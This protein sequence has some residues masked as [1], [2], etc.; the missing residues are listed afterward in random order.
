MKRRDFIQYGGA[1]TA[2]ALMPLSCWSGPDQETYPM[3]LQLY[4]VRD[5][6]ERD[7]IGTLLRL[8]A[9]GYTHFESYGFDT[10]TGQ[11]YGMTPKEFKGQLDALGLSTTS[12]HYGFADQFD[13]SH[14]HLMDYT[15]RCI[16]GALAIDDQYIVWPILREAHHSLLGYQQLAEKLN[17]IG[18]RCKAA[19]VG[20]AYHNFGYDFAQYDGVMGYDVVLHDTQADLVQMEVDFYWVMHAGVISPRALI[21]KAPGRFP[22]WHIKDMDK[23]TR[24]YTEMGNGSIDYKNLLPDPKRSGLMHYYVEQGGNFLINSMESVKQSARYVDQELGH[25]FR[26]TTR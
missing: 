23:I 3:G 24:D 5:F 12:G 26:A 19:G 11:Y 13:R 1:I 8:K 20:F 10:Q 2:A 6:M 22:L 15:D 25:L 17:L 9:M 14:E 21:E 7:P 4:T 16:E 18:E